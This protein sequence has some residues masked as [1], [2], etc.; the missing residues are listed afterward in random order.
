MILGM[1][2]TKVGMKESDV[3]AVIE[4]QYAKYGAV[5]P[6]YPSIVGAGE[7][8]TILHYIKNNDYLKNNDL[9]LIDAGA[10]YLGYVKDIIQNMANKWQIY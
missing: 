4:Y 10:E 2:V 8:A 9:L 5:R 3:E 6:A 1:K 7:N